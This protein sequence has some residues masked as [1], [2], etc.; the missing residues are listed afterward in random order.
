MTKEDYELC[1]VCLDENELNKD[2]TRLPCKHCFHTT[3]IEKW[4]LEN[5]DCPMCK[6]DF[7]CHEYFQK[8]DPNYK[9]RIFLNELRRE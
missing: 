1:P 7:R 8:P 4:L 9:N 6:R 5:N 3:C 2:F